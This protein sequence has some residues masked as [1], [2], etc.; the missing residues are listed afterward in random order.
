MVLCPLKGVRIVSVFRID[1]GRRIARSK[2]KEDREKNADD[3]DRNFPFSEH[4]GCAP[5]SNH[6][7]GC[8]LKDRAVSGDLIGFAA[9]YRCREDLPRLVQVAAGKE[10]AVDF[11]SVLG[12]LLDLVVIA[13]VRD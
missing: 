8:D 5:R 10:Y 2:N 9:D 7:A 1:P 13:V 6:R 11:G 3:D 12:P 4:L